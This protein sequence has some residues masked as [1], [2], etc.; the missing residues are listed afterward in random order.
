MR[1]KRFVLPELGEGINT[2][3]SKKTGYG[4]INFLQRQCE[5]FL[6]VNIIVYQKTRF[7]LVH[8]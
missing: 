3:I 1:Y 6:I 7:M 4:R 5:N 8:R 2:V